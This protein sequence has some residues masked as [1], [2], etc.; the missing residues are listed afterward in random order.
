MDKNM[1][2][3]DDLF[4][5]R[6]AGGEEKE[7]AGAWLRMQD[8]LDKD[9]PE[10]VAVGYNWRRMFGYLTGLLLLSAASVGGYMMYTA[11]QQAD[12]NAVASVSKISGVLGSSGMSTTQQSHDIVSAN[13]IET[14]STGNTAANSNTVNNN[15][16]SNHNHKL[17]A[18]TIAASKKHTAINIGNNNV[19]TTVQPVKTNGEATHEKLVASNYGFSKA[20][21][22]QS[23]SIIKPNNNIP[24][25]VKAAQKHVD[26]KQ[27]SSNVVST[28]EHKKIDGESVNHN[29]AATENAPVK[30]SAKAVAAENKI[31]PASGVSSVN[32]T[33]A[34]SKASENKTLAKNSGMPGNSNVKKARVTKDSINMITTKQSYARRGVMKVDTIE[35]GKVAHEMLVTE[36]PNKQQPANDIVPAANANIKSNKENSISLASNI[37]A[38][39]RKGSGYNES[40]FEEMVKNVKPDFSHVTFYPGIIGGINTSI[41]KSNPISGFQ[42][43]VTGSLNL[44]S[45]W[46]LF[47]EFKYMQNFN[48]NGSVIKDNYNNN[49]NLA[50]S[51]GQA[52]YS[53]DS[54]GHSYSYTTLSS[55]HLPVGVRYTMGQLAV[56]CGADFAYNFAIVNSDETS[57][58]RHVSQ[59]TNTSQPFS[60]NYDKQTPKIAASDLNARFGVGAVLGIGYYINPS[61]FIDM[62]MVDNLWDNT[63]TNGAFMVSEQIYNRP[64]LQLNISYRFSKN[65][66]RQPAP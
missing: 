47:A 57:I 31:I 54:I 8:L 15:T 43:G 25:N 18:S 46:S 14:N 35:K 40:R 9:M 48:M 13:Q 51:G 41:G 55:L 24:E 42:L 11:H 2:N 61:T 1:I 39:S 21:K 6:L 45:N 20:N 30:H 50:L 44:S 56:F 19:A 38:S 3:I 16:P 5:Q 17:L 58:T 23:T 26:A 59:V 53:W 60:Y 4:K 36:E 66:Y 12:P 52:K 49:L 22:S 28:S 27:A 63:K 37:K 64:T 10:R 34:S 62:R 32:N 33:P 7:P 29:I 65:K